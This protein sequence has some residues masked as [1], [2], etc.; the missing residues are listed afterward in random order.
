[1][2]LSQVSE[3]STLPEGIG[4]PSS[5]GGADMPAPEPRGRRAAIRT[6]AVS[7]LLQSL[8]YLI[9]RTM[10]TVNLEVWWLS[11]PVLLLEIHAFVSLALFA[12]SLW[13][14]DATPPAG[15]VLSAPGSVAVLIPTYDEPAEV[16]LPS[17]AA[18]V[19]LR[20]AHETWVLDDG[21]R[22]S[23]R[24]LAESLGARYLA[25]SDNAHA[26]AGNINHALAHIDADFVAVL[27]AD[28][29]ARPELLT[30]TLGYFSDP[31]VAVVQTPQ[32]FYNLDSFEHEEVVSR[33]HRRSRRRLYNEQALFYRAIQPGKNR[34]GAAF[35]CGTGAVARVTALEDVGGISTESITEDIHTTIRLHHK[36]WKSVYHNEVLARGLA[37]ADAAQYQVQRLRWGAGA[38]QVLRKD[39]PLFKSGLSLTQRL[40]YAA[41][42][43]GWFDSWRSL[44]YLLVPIAT[45]ITG[46]VPIKAN[47]LVFAAAF[48]TTFIV[49]R[50]ALS[51]LGR[52]YAPPLLSTVFDV[53]RMPANLKATLSIFTAKKLSFRVTRK[54]RLG[55]E[56]S[57]QGTPLL[58]IA[59]LVASVIAAGFF[60]ATLLGMLPLHYSVP[61]ATIAAACWMALNSYVVARAISRIRSDRFA[62][63]RRA[64]VRFDVSVDGALDEIPCKIVDVSLTGARVELDQV[65]E[66]SLK[67]GLQN[68]YL[69][70][71]V[72]GSDLRMRAT[73]CSSRESA[74]GTVLGLQFTPGQERL[75]ANLAQAL[76]NAQ[77]VPEFEAAA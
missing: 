21:N 57:R 32:E 31:K 69:E 51:A 8:A 34:W 63:E 65:L 70:F 25:R 38:M 20:P 53:V 29:V 61:E 27:D 14:L 64:S 62:S 37:A 12:F 76:F 77:L 54:G 13:D 5:F 47:P 6:A 36:G 52:G 50:I 23:I 56:R 40:A 11:V 39:N 3:P 30:N 9:W 68:S 42:L 67:P 10:F 16:L 59:M 35:W 4:G 66:G 58:L 28:H 74:G 48:G 33:G 60:G 49:Q 2:T 22:D 26:K 19:A 41:T 44:G 17:V 55:D 7:A 43:L 73:V 18:A 24:I 46:A 45:V 1:M 75:T 15:G 71:S 72:L